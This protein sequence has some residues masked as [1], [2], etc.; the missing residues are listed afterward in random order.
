MSEWTDDVV[1]ERWFSIKHRLLGRLQSVFR[2][3][4]QNGLT[5]TEIGER[6]G[7]PDERVTELLKGQT[8]MPIQI[9]HRLALGMGY[10]LTFDITPIPDSPPKGEQ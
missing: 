9:M 7:Y 1:M 2:A 5:V 4:K 3:E 8:D 6:I 10:R